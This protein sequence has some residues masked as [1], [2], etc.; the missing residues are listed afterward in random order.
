MDGD[1]RLVNSPAGR[2]NSG[3]LEICVSEAWSTVCDMGWNAP[4]ASVACRQLGFSRYGETFDLLIN[5]TRVSKE[6]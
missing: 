1:I 6:A 2:N 5:D 3:R 4:D